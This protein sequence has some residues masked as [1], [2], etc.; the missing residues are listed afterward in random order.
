MWPAVQRSSKRLPRTSC[1][2]RYR[3][4]AW[5]GAASLALQRSSKRL[6]RTSA[7]IVIAHRLEGSRFAIWLALHRGSGRLPGTT[8][9]AIIAHRL[10]GSRFANVASSAA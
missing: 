7:D 8:A 10:E 6:P 3:P 2:R 9:D 1:Q 5:R 4:T